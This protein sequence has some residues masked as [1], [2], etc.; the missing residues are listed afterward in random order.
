MPPKRK[1]ANDSPHLQEPATKAAR[2]GSTSGTTAS[3]PI[4]TRGTA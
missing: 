1:A 2:A 4:A 3:A